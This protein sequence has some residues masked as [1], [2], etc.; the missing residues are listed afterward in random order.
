[1]T[2]LLRNPLAIP[3]ALSAVVAM[4]LF[5]PEAS[6][7]VTKAQC[8]E[9]DTQ[10]QQL[11][12]DEKLGASRTQLKVCVDPACPAL[13]RDDCAQ[14]LDE[15]DRVQPTLVFEAKDGRGRDLSAVKVSMDGQVLV[16]S[17]SGSAI[18]VEP[19]E[20]TFLFEA[21]GEKSITRKLVLREG[22]KAR[23]EPIVFGSGVVVVGAP[24]PPDDPSRGK[25]QRTAGLVL[26]GLGIVGLGIGGAF[27]GLAASRWSAAK[28]DCSTSATCTPSDNTAANGERSNALTLATV[29]TVS[30]V[31]GGVLGAGGLI[32]FLT[33]PRAGE[34][35]PAQGFE[36]VPTGGP[37]HTG[38]MVRGWF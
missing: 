3:L 34:S 28:S 38:M 30:F 21:A 2:L 11:R 15:L 9:A 5:A 13:I 22:D 4:S 18:P 17:V 24:P 6:A 12:R 29:S 7:D 16:E 14:R 19:G 23:H 8:A 36:V 31:A 20:H 32:L 26:G 27:A 33:A 10:A 35:R 25:G 37:G 1:M